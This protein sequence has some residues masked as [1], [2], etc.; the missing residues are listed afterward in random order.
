M[1]NNIK[2]IFLQL[3]LLW[4]AIIFILA[5]DIRLPDFQA[6]KCRYLNRYKYTFSYIKLSHRNVLLD[7]ASSFYVS[8][9]AAFLFYPE[10]ITYTSVS[11]KLIG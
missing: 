2:F 5:Y 9:Q 3:F 1:V 7:H 4:C 8:A 10:E 6:F 11:D